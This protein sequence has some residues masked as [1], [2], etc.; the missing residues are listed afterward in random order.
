GSEVFGF[1]PGKGAKKAAGFQ[2]MWDHPCGQALDAEVRRLPIGGNGPFVAETVVELNARGKVI[3]RWPMPV[4]YVPHAIRGKQLLVAQGD[5]GFW[6]RSTGAFTK[7]FALPPHNDR[8]VF[9]CN[10]KS[11]FGKSDYAG[12]Q[13]FVDLA[14]HRER[15]LGYQGI[16]S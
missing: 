15:T 4:D 14:S 1:W 10:L 8:Q 16:C 7:A 3:G 2:R 5:K 13:V 9:Q 6:I 12:C 11:V